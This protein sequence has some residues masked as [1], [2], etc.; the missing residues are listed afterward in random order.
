MDSN[1]G[2]AAESNSID[3]HLPP[4]VSII[5]YDNLSQLSPLPGTNRRVYRGTFHTT[6]IALKFL[7]GHTEED[8]YKLLTEIQFLSQLRHPRVLLMLGVVTDLPEDFEATVGL[9]T[10]YM[11]GGSLFAALHSVDS[12]GYRF[13]HMSDKVRVLLDVADGM[14]YL[15]GRDVIHRDV[16]SLNVLID[17]DGRAKICDFGISRLLSQHATHLSSVG[18][19]VA[20]SAPEALLSGGYVRKQCDVYSFGVI[21]WEVLTNKVP[22]DGCSLSEIVLHVYNDHKRLEIPTANDETEDLV[23]MLEQCLQR[24]PDDRPS[25]GALYDTLQDVLVECES[26]ER[27]KEVPREFLCSISYEIMEDPVVCADGHTYDRSHIEKWLQNN[28]TSPLTGLI[29]PDT[30][31]KPNHALRSLIETYRRLS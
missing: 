31:L 23:D 10:E 4:G 28:D 17:S 16:K 9:V 3:S 19:T 26:R 7:G 27:Q 13:Q 1:T 14:R 21:L 8:T 15:H 20:W 24:N 18:G 5:P 12:A 2:S 11:S 29:L 25:F 22:W 30:S 6:A